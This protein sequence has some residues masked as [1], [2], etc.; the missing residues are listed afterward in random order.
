M[1][2]YDSTCKIIIKCGYNK[3]NW[4]DFKSK[5]PEQVYAVT[6]SNQ[7]LVSELNKYIKAA[8][9]KKG[10]SKENRSP[11]LRSL[12]NVL[13]VGEDE[14]YEEEQYR[15]KVQPAPAAEQQSN[16][17]E[18]EEPQSFAERLVKKQRIADLR[19]YNCVKVDL[20]KE[21]QL[22]HQKL[23]FGSPRARQELVE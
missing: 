2:K 21:R 17:E 5:H 11:Q 1:A 14:R 3:A 20:V 6:D 19:Q 22:A 16:L 8:E 4:L 7:G 15:Q 10:S 18:E 13:Y 23:Q 9:T 12:P